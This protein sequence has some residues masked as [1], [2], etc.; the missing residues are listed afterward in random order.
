MLERIEK[1]EIEERCKRNRK[2]SNAESSDGMTGTT[3]EKEEITDGSQNPQ[4]KTGKR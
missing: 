2:N 1:T 3:Y 4:E